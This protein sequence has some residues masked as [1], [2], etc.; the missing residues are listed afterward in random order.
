MGMFN[1][2]I[3]KKEKEVIKKRPGFYLNYR[4][5]QYG[6]TQWVKTEGYG[7]SGDKNLEQTFASEGSGAVRVDFDC[8]LILHVEAIKQK[9]GEVSLSVHSVKKG[10]NDWLDVVPNVASYD[11]D[12]RKRGNL[13][14]LTHTGRYCKNDIIVIRFTNAADIRVTLFGIGN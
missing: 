14:K 4:T 7:F 9:A 6:L 13:I 5:T 10:S 1:N 12:T 3:K 11:E 8:T 2:E